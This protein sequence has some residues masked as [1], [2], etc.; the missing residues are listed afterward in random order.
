[1]LNGFWHA[2]GG[3]CG[4]RRC[5]ADAADQM[6]GLM[7]KQTLAAML[8]AS[9]AAPLVDRPAVASVR[10]LDTFDFA[11]LTGW[12]DRNG[13]PIDT[14][15]TGSFTGYLEPSGF[16]ELGD[17]TSFTAVFNGVDVLPITVL[18]F[19]SFDPTGGASS[20]DFI[21]DGETKTACVGAAA[22]FSP[23]CNPNGTNPVDS[24]GVFNFSGVLVA[25]TNSLANIK[26]VSSIPVP[27]PSTWSM[28]V[29]GLAGLGL[30]R[31]RASKALRGT[32]KLAG[33]RQSFV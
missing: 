8:L 23:I 28:L 19:F 3:L 6:E 1:M 31:A 27:E 11:M 14:S 13:Q 24:I 32:Q 7:V 9:L 25:D 30:A 21:D 33:A 17:L 22:T 15:L 12:R 4:R 29:L 16:I 20:L 5:G 2:G 26:L 18:S 10:T